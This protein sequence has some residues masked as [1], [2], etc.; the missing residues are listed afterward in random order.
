MEQLHE[1]HRL[2]WI[3]SLSLEKRAEL[4]EPFIWKYNFCA[5]NFYKNIIIIKRMIINFLN[6]RKK[7]IRDINKYNSIDEG[8]Y[9]YVRKHNDIYY[10][11]DL[12]YDNNKLD[13]FIN[14]DD[15]M[16]HR[17]FALQL[18]DSPTNIKKFQSFELSKSYVSDGS[19]SI[20]N[21]MKL[22]YSINTFL[23]EINKHP[24]FNDDD[25][26][27]I[28][29][30]QFKINEKTYDMI[31]ELWDIYCVVNI[32]SRHDLNDYEI[33]LFIYYQDLYNNK[34]K[35]LNEIQN[36]KPLNSQELEDLQESSTETN[37]HPEEL[38]EPTDPLNMILCIGCSNQCR[39]NVMIAVDDP[40]INLLCTNCYNN[41]K[42]INIGI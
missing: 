33:L 13:D 39:I 19:E 20:Y 25:K 2:R 35:Q 8:I 30:T 38:E 37:Q 5:D 42:E 16:K 14:V 29:K 26:K 22:N 18:G 6:N 21:K 34:I 7:K 12:R 3:K 11:Y 10:T 23:P 28:F 24:I 31:E 40:E 17:N 4:L 27:I 36:Y 1:I 32:M 41:Y 15:F 9:R